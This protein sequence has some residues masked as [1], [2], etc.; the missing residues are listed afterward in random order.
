MLKILSSIICLCTL[1]LFFSVLRTESPNPVSLFFIIY[2]FVL[3]LGVYNHHPLALFGWK[4]LVTLLFP[5]TLI[6]YYAAF[7]GGPPYPFAE[8]LLYILVF[9][10]L[11]AATSILWV[12]IRSYRQIARS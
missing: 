4:L 11:I 5:V 1:I 9:G 3:G 8:W 7:D 12:L 6:A 2:A 10:P